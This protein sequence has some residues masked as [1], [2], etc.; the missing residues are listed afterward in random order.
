MRLQR[1]DDGVDGRFGSLEGLGVGQRGRG[2]QRRR[3]Q[4]AQMDL[5]SLPFLLGAA[6]VPAPGLSL[7]LMLPW[8]GARR[9]SGRSAMRM[10][11]SLADRRRGRHRRGRH[12]RGS[13]RRATRRRRHSARRRPCRRRTRRR[14]SAWLPAGCRRPERACSGRPR[15]LRGRAL[16]GRGDAPRP[17]AWLPARAPLGLLQPR[18]APCSAGRARPRGSPRS[19]R[20]SCPSAVCLL[21]GWRATWPPPASRCSGDC[22]AARPAGPPRPARRS[23]FASSCSRDCAPPPLASSFWRSWA[24]PGRRPAAGRWR[25]PSRTPAARRRCRCAPGPARVAIRPPVAVPVDVDAVAAAVDVDVD[26]VADAGCDSRAD[27]AGHIRRRRPS[28]SAP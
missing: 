13:W 6:L 12:R 17:A 2:A 23:R 3:E 27:R 20:P 24:R 26:V 22:P 8:P 14:R 21:P 5:R 16:A 25:A 9:R 11:V 7:P 15:G 28:R 18:P 1:L 10:R 4:A 19:G